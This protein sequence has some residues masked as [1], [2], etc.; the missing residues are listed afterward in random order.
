MIS[1]AEAKEKAAAGWF[2]V[3]VAFEG[4]AVNK[5]AVK[6]A[7]EGLMSHLEADHKIKVYAKEFLEPE[8][9]ENPIKGISE[10]WSLVVNVNFVSKSFHDLVQVII[11]YG[12]SAVEI[13]GP[14]KKEMQINEAQ[15]VLNNIAGM[16]HRYAAAGLGGMVLVRGKE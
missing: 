12:P 1:S 13:L 8:K 11:E 4:L 9:V 14:S 7:L 6:S 10:A 16:M 15:D 3:W 5:E 2:D